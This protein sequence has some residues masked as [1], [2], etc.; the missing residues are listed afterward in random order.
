M[1]LVFLGP[2]GV[3]KGTQAKRLSLA[4]RIPH[5]A[6]GDM[7]RAAI[8]KGEATGLE[9]RSYVHSGRL[10]PDEL[11]IRIVKERLL[12]AD[13][14]GGFILDGF[15]RTHEQAEALSK[16]GEGNRIDR[17]LFF[18]L[19]EEA[20]VKRLSGRHVCGK[21]Y[22]IYHAVNRP[23]VQEGVCDL[24][25]ASLVFR[26]DD[27]PDAVIERLR[28][29]KSETFPLVQY[30]ERQGCLSRINAGGSVEEVERCVE[31]AAQMGVSPRD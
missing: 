8:S 23:P 27:Q 4:H 3:G 7:L 21:C 13:M 28:T 17:V 29:Y 5:L 19:N 9:A 26:K 1:R 16:M 18:D 30:Y 2:P 31:Q 20:L 14:R 12:E 10:V 6:T 25:S 15:P 11:V 22:E 24:C